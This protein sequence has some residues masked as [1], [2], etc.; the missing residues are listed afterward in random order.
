MMTVSELIEILRTHNPDAR[1]MIDGFDSYAYRDLEAEAIG[2]G[3]MKKMEDGW[4]FSE[5]LDAK[6]IDKSRFIGESFAA[7]SLV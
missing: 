5:Y 7:V 1:V 2:S 3:D 4:G 6:Y